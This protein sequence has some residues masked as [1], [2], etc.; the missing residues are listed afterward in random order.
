MGIPTSIGNLGVYAT[1]TNVTGWLWGR[2][3]RLPEM[4]PVDMEDR[5]EKGD[6][7]RGASNRPNG[8]SV[9]WFRIIGRVEKIP[10][11]PGG[12]ELDGSETRRNVGNDS[13]PGDG[14]G[15]M[16]RNRKSKEMDTWVF[17]RRAKKMGA[18]QSTRGVIREHSVLD[19]Q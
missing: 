3:R 4:G 9:N 19:H 13:G 15:E 16:G 8:K 1:A 10:T 17:T 12:G 11:G 5:V 2:Q 6:R 18:Q 7:W 14:R